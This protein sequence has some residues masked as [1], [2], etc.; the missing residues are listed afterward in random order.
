M[1]TNSKNNKKNNSGFLR[2]MIVTVSVILQLVL[3]AFL[4]MIL[5]QNY[6][7]IFL[8]FQF[9]GLIYALYLISKGYGS[10]Y[11]VAWIIIILM[12]P[13][14]GYL[15]YLLW[16]KSPVSPKKNRE[17]K[18]IVT[19]HIPVSE[20]QEEVINLF[21]ENHPDS[22]GYSRFLKHEG[23]PLYSDTA[24]KYYPLGD[25]QFRDMLEDLNKAKKFI[26]M[27]YF[28]ISRGE[29]WDEIFFILKKK[30][31][32]GV[33]VRILYDDFGSIFNLPDNFESNLKNSGIKVIA[34]NPVHRYI[35]RLYLNFRNHQKIT[36][37]DGNIAYTGGTN[38]ADEYANIIQR[39][40]HWK[41]NCIR[42]EGAAVKSLTITF[43]QMWETETKIFESIDNF[44]PDCSLPA[45]G[46]YQ[47][48]S[49]GPANNP[50]NPAE[51]IYKKMIHGAKNYVYIMTPYLVIDESMMNALGLAAK[52]GTDVRI[53]T[54]KIEDKWYVHLVTRSNYRKLLKSGVKIYE[55]TPGYIHS[56]TILC[57][58]YHAVVGSIN[59]DYRSFHLHFENGVWICGSKVVQ[60]IKDDFISTLKISEEIGL[61]EVENIP[62]TKRAVQ[63]VLRVF[64]PLL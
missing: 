2:L 9:A 44:M 54:P 59:M 6:I 20:N 42:L 26:F 23:F 57:D 19:R 5:R 51:G 27:E 32:E 48:F 1:K 53:I 45:D 28:I 16:G 52:S 21:A 47:P 4:V 3:L 11:V 56:K 15:L 55:Y 63:T 60:D 62:L 25:L 64:A 40:G 38:L 24:S 10:A 34:F 46:F 33:E 50:Q 49:D 37:I 61:D 13:V 43:L 22:I 8:F 31:S 41:D 14:F 36:I 58:D 30:S 29:L 17:M 7:Y 39:F 12:L 18:K 35:H